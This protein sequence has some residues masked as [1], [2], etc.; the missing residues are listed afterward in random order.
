MITSRLAGVIIV[1]IAVFIMTGC[2]G[3]NDSPVLPDPG[4][5]SNPESIQ[6]A[7][8]EGTSPRTL[9]WG[10]WGISIDPDTWDV[11]ITPLRAA[12]FTANV[13]QYLQPPAGSLSNLTVIVTDDSQFL[14]Q[15]IVEVDVRITHPFPSSPEYTGFD[16]MGV[17]MHNGSHASTVGYNNRWPLAP[18]DAILLN[19]DGYTRWMNQSE[20]TTTG[21]LGFTPGALGNAGSFSATINPYKYY[22]DG[23]NKNQSISNFYLSAGSISK[24]GLFSSGT[25]NTREYEI[26]FPMLGG[27]PVLT[28]QYA[29]IARWDDPSPSP[30]INVPDDFPDTANCQE[31]FYIE[32][33]DT[34]STLN[35]H[36]SVGGSGTLSVDIEIFDWQGAGNPLGFSD[37]MIGIFLEGFNSW[38]GLSGFE[39]CYGSAVESAGSCGNS[40]IYHA[41]I[42]NCSPTQSGTEDLMVNIQ[43]NLPMDYKSG[44]GT[45][46][47]VS[48][49]LS[50]YTVASIP[51]S[52]IANSTP[53]VPIPTGP[54]Y[55]WDDQTVTFTCAATDPDIGDTLT[56]MWSIE[57]TG[58]PPSYIIPGDSPPGTDTLTIQLGSSTGYPL[59]PYDVRCM[60]QDSSGM[61]NDTGYSPILNEIIYQPPYTNGP[62]PSQVDQIL[63]Q[64]VPS[65]QG[66]WGCPTYYDLFYNAG[67]GFPPFNHPDISILSGPSLGMAGVMAICDE[68][69]IIGGLPSPPTSF[70]TFTC[71]FATGNAPSWTWM[72]LGVPPGGPDVFPSVVHFD[73]NIN[74]EYFITN[75][76]NLLAPNKL[77]NIPDLSL[78]QHYTA[79]APA[80]FNNDL[81]TS[82]FNAL[83]WDYPADVTNGFD[84]GSVAVPDNP[85]MYAVYTQDQ[86]GILGWCMGAVNGPMN[87]LPVN[88]LM[89]PSGGTQ[90]VNTPVDGGGPGVVAPLAASLV[91]AVPG[92]GG[93]IFGIGPNGPCPSG[94]MMYPEP[95]YA[96]AIDDD[97]DDN[98]W[99]SGLTAPVNHWTLAAVIDA[100][101][102]LEMYEM[103]MGGASPAQILPW[104]YYKHGS[105]MG[106]QPGVYALDCEFIS[107]F[108]GFPGSTTHVAEDDL[109]AVLLTEQIGGFFCVE[110]FSVTPGLLTSI[111][112]GPPIPLPAMGYAVHGVAY[113]LDV[114]EVTGDIYVIHESAAAPGGLAITYFK[115]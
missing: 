62:A 85:P 113:R 41:D 3:N 54:P 32:V 37:E 114:D 112:I 53:T 72:T 66:M 25:T 35:Y 63:T 43:S 10:L 55:I 49:Q 105:F 68:F 29:V 13:T 11:E 86:S 8:V 59:G 89:F 61:P 84:H 74:A 57:P 67:F 78:V 106:G 98:P 33:R 102:D 51:V 56:F 15:G 1:L 93:G 75:S 91:S 69:G 76:M 99:T 65:L 31:A 109:L 83:S 94:G 77:A 9:D 104:S 19:H 4:S 115:Y 38:V 64:A 30:P 82:L 16:V 111:A 107:N 6:T 81:Y 24:R 23:L 79:A 5:E 18:N 42:I 70:V 2:S 26:Q 34:G 52:N 71:P 17:F 27:S 92:S 50:G 100:D 22:A 103:D 44:F 88:F 20:F 90:P 39:D 45:T 80:I 48:A 40:R 58:N 36:P 95:Y 21:L 110:I 7:V 101:R 12:S 46:Y 96:L 87:P 73:A 47:P 14:S 108:S 28:F 97:P 60:V